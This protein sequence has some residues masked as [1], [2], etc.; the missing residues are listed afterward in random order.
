MNTIRKM[1]WW[2]HGFGVVSGPDGGWSDASIDLTK[3]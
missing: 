1:Q 3:T 2:L